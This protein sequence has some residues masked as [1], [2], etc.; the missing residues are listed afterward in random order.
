MPTPNDFKYLSSR[1]LDAVRVL[2]YHGIYDIAYHDSGYIIEFGL[3]AIIC[4]KNN[5]ED[6]PHDEKYRS[7]HYDKLVRLAGLDEELAIR[8]ATN[9]EFMKNWSITTKWSV[10]MRYQPI[11][12]DAKGVITSFLNAATS[13]NGGVMPWIRKH[14]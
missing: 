10:N 9:R 14:W 13:E 7:H 5:A 1:R 8:K 11:G 2:T 3:K 6:Y 4:K 12:K